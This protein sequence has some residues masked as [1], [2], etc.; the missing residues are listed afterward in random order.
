MQT[1]KQFLAE[2]AGK[3]TAGFQDGEAFAEWIE[4]I[5]DD[6]P[7][8]MCHDGVEYDE[9]LDLVKFEI[10]KDLDEDMVYVDCKVTFVS[11]VACNLEVRQWAA[12]G[13]VDDFEDRAV[14]DE[15]IA[16]LKKRGV[17][18]DVDEDGFFTVYADISKLRDRALMFKTKEDYEQLSQAFEQ[19]GEGS[20]MMEDGDIDE[21]VHA[22]DLSALIKVCDKFAA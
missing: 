22:I 21:M 6:H 19:A 1:F 15:K 4:Q 20:V 17:K 2:A 10:E 8:L 12:S 18:V 11:P 3:Q 16:E 9:D 13:R 5:N 14:L 7:I